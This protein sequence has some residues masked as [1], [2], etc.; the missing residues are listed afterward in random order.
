VEIIKKIQPVTLSILSALLLSISL[1]P[2]NY[3]Y[4]AW[5]SFI[6]FFIALDNQH[7]LKSTTILGFLYGAIF[8]IITF[9]GIGEIKVFLYAL[10][11]FSFYVS[12]F[13]IGI[14]IVNRRAKLYSFLFFSS[15]WWTSL[16]Y[17]RTIGNLSFPTNIALSQYKFPFLIQIASIT[18]SYG[19]SF[20]IML[21][22][23]CLF[24]VCKYFYNRIERFYL[25]RMLYIA[26]GHINKS[27]KLLGLETK[28]FKRKLQDCCSSKDIVY[29]LLYIIPI[30]MVFIGYGGVSLSKKEEILSINVSIIQGSIPDWLY[31]LEKWDEKYSKI[32]ETTYLELTSTAIKKNDSSIIIWPETPIHRQ[33]MKISYLKNMLLEFSKAGNNF[34]I[35]GSPRID[36]KRNCKYNSVFVLSPKGNIIDYYDKTKLVPF[37]EHFFTPSNE[38]KIIHASEKL[39][40]GINICF[41]STY[42][43]ISRNAVKKGANLLIISTNDT[44]LKKTKMSYCH[45]ANAVF[46]AVEN[47]RY[48]IRAAQS[49]ISMVINPY[50]RIL[51]QSELFKQCVLS[52]KVGLQE[53]LTFY[54]KFG[55]LFCYL[56]IGLSIIFILKSA[57][58]R[59]TE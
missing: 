9:Y 12:I 39:K 28:V 43:S 45:A 21:C 56:C 25:L 48:V 32:I 51:K 27:A 53:E 35:V 55:D 38:V 1:P 54:T 37:V 23:S 7:N 3:P 49:G 34:F 29:T 17:M 8:S 20:S 33:I 30:I 50:G 16:E 4:L 15:L 26:N 10:F 57:S 46:R 58:N 52:G 2:S 18:G 14:V 59:T 6:P 44:C 13:A 41:E 42:P 47:R 31:G 40:L 24:I 36:I 5:I 11:Y 22:N 19:V